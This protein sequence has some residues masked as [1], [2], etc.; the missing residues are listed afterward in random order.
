MKNFLKTFTTLAITGLLMDTGIK[1]FTQPKVVKTNSKQFNIALLGEINDLKFPNLNITEQSLSKLKESNPKNYTALWINKSR[2]DILNSS[3]GLSII[4]DYLNNK[5]VVMFINNSL[6]TM[7]KSDQEK[8]ITNKSNQ[9]YKIG[10]YLW[11]DN[12]SNFKLGS[13]K[14]DKKAN[15]N[16]VYETLLQKTI[17]Y[18]NNTKFRHKNK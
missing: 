5:K 18:S 16:E 6:L 15:L 9:I 8:P 17:Q 3:T 12:E 1:A 11:Q 2:K 7:L 14:I 13:I 4:K 10:Y